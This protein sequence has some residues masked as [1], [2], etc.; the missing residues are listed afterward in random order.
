MF[1]DKVLMI[2]GG[3]G[4][5]ADAV[6]RKFLKT[7][8]KEVRI[9]SRDEKK[10]EEVRM[11]HKDP[12]IK[13]YIGDVR[14]LDSVADAMVG[15]DYVFH[16]ASLTQ[17]PSCEFY[18]LEAI[19]TN[20]LGGEN[21]LSAAMAARVKQVMVLS[22]DK[23]VYPVN[24][25]GMSNAMMEK[26]MLA[27]SRMANGDGTVMCGTRHGNILAARGSVI[28]VFVRQIKQGKPLTVTDPMM[29]RFM[30]SSEDAVDLVVFA[31]QHASPGDIF[32]P[33]APAATIGTLAQALKVIFKS[34]NPVNVIGT[35]HGEKLYETLMTREEMANAEDLGRYSR[36]KAGNRDL[37]YDAF[38]T[39]GEVKI[40]T[41]HDYNSQNTHQLSV[42]EMVNLLL[43]LDYIK[44]ELGGAQ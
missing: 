44:S 24:G 25:M 30:M 31:Y 28:P 43:T 20:A 5:F 7:G 26:L 29:T 23:A 13:S 9:F 21:V 2:T 41:A 22:S 16:A 36:I 18:P 15:V 37:N 38:T 40:S 8:V 17:V 6:L 33:K 39:E 32:V 1:T 3:T 4:S 27:K 35:R 42:E 34:G 12:R 19:Q 10:Q 14:I 11:L